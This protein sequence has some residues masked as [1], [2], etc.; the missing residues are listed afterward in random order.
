MKKSDRLLM[1]NFQLRKAVCGVLWLFAR[2]FCDLNPGWS[3]GGWVAQLPKSQR[4]SHSL[5]Y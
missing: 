1:P 2:E 5:Y 4:A 3:D